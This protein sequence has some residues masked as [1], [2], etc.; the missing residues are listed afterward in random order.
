MSQKT[1][2]WPPVRRILPDVLAFLLGLGAAWM[3]Q[4]TTTDLVW[5]L[6]LGSLVLGYVTILSTIGGGVYL[7]AHAVFHEAFPRE[8]WPTA[9]LAGSA[10]ALFFLGFF[11]LHF[12]GFHAGHAVFLS[13]F[14]PINGLPAADF[15]AAFMN[16]I[17]LWKTV[18]RHLLLPYGVF[19]VPAII[20]ERRNVFASIAGAVKAVHRGDDR[21]LVQ[22][23]GQWAKGRAAAMRDP[24]FRPYINVIRM[25]L[26][27]F[28]FAF[29]HAM[30]AESF[31]VYAVVYLVYF[32]PWRAFRADASH[33]QP[34]AALAATALHDGTVT[35]TRRR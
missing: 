23:A 15:V 12:C 14:F 5:S 20:A 2:Q 33:T 24:F 16:P 27:I 7:G 29:C 17:L 1:L 21:R 26:L 28:F 3:L 22:D 4:W 6:W 9:I 10:A 18:F 34:E 32:F 30:K 35:A 19:L 31:F 11:S 13:S 8:H 25:H